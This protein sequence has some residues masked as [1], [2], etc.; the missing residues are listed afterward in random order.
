MEEKAKDLVINI[1]V[2]YGAAKKQSVIPLK[3]VNGTTAYGAIK[4]SNI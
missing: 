4:L 2:A 3:V 1:K